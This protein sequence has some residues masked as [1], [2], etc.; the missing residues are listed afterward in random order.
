MRMQKLQDANLN[1]NAQPSWWPRTNRAVCAIF[2]FAPLFALRE[3]R[4]C[5]PFPS[6]QE[7]IRSAW[8]VGHK[9]FNS[10]NRMGVLT[11]ERGFVV[12]FRNSHH[13]RR[14]P[15]PIVASSAV[16]TEHAQSYATGASQPWAGLHAVVIG[17]GPAGST[18]A[19]VSKLCSPN[20]A[21]IITEAIIKMILC[22]A[23]AGQARNGRG[24]V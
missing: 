20:L 22:L 18:A 16:S 23:A 11:A 14:G 1:A 21:L 6:Y 2:F 15:R 17:A 24:C 7:P 8:Q 4:C 13:K 10:G 19:M 5:L 9:L 12:P 3:W